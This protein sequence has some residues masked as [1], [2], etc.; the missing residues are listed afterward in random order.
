MVE[1]YRPNVHAH[2]RRAMQLRHRKVVTQLENIESAVTRD[3]QCA[4]LDRVIFRPSGK[5][6]YRLG[7]A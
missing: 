5:L 3:R 6:V 7:F 2:V 1:R 4:H